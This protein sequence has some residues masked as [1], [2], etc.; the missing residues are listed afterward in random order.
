MTVEM[1]Y[2]QIV[3]GAKSL[4]D[5]KTEFDK[6]IDELDKISADLE[7]SWQGYAKT[8]FAEAYEDIRPT[9]V[10][11]SALLELYQSETIIAVQDAAETDQA[12]A[13]RM[14]SKLKG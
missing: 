8:E 7:S 10:K 3:D 14:D 11:F 9:L 2:E 6:L 5:R 1:L 13:E 4:A 12:S